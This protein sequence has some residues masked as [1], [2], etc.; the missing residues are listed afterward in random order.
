MYMIEKEDDT[1]V[2]LL[3]ETKAENMRLEDQRLVAIQ[4]KF[5]DTLKEHHVEF[6]EATSAQQVY[7]RIRKLAGED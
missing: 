3:V 4:K 6:E 1:T 7:S 5:F 2:Y